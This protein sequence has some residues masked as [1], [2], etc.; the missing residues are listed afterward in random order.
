MYQMVSYLFLPWAIIYSNSNQFITSHLHRESS[1][2]ISVQSALHSLYL[3]LVFFIFLGPVVQS[4]VTLMSS[5]MTDLLTVVAKVFSNTL[6][7]MLQKS[8]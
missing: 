4:I 1:Y 6:I 8:E 2:A 7:F 5:F 3:T